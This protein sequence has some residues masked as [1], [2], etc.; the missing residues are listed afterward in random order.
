MRSILSRTFLLILFL[1][2][3]GI[4]PSPLSAAQK[5]RRTSV[6]FL[7]RG[8]AIY[9]SFS[10][11]QTEF[12]LAISDDDNKP[13]HFAR[14]LY[15]HSFSHPEIPDRL[16]DSGQVLRLQLARSAKCDETFA[17]LTTA[18]LPGPYGTLRVVDPLRYVVGASVPQISGNDIVPCY[19]LDPRKVKWHR[20][21]VEID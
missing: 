17:S 2:A 13:L 19:V 7:A 15:R 10:G 12:L 5:P 20:G 14:L 1:S 16:V 18:W 9:S 3:L 4:V 8:T 11:N 21:Q 6:R